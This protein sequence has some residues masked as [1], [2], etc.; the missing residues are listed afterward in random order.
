MLQITMP[1]EEDIVRA[2]LQMAVAVVVRI[3]RAVAAVLMPVIFPATPEKEFQIFQ[4]PP[5]QLHGIWRL[6][7]LPHP[8]LPEEERVGIHSPAVTKMH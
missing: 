5:G 3:M 4:M 7:T 2:L 1:W 8:L 6:Q